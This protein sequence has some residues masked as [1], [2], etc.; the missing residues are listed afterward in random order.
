MLTV[1]HKCVLGFIVRNIEV[2][3]SLSTADIDTR[4]VHGRTPLSWACNRCDAH[5][6]WQLLQFGADPNIADN[7]GYS[8]LLNAAWRGC[9][10]LCILLIES[11]ADILHASKCGENALHYASKLSSSDTETF[12]QRIL[13]AGG[14]KL[15]NVQD[16][17]GRAPLSWAAEFGT[18]TL[19]R[20]LL[21]NDAD[22]E[23]KD[24]KVWTPLLRSLRY[25]HND[26]TSLLLGHGASHSVKDKDG[27][28]SLHFAVRYGN[29]ATL[30]ILAGF[31]LNGLDPEA[32]TI[33]GYTAAD[34]FKFREESTPDEF[35]GA[36]QRLLDRLRFGSDS[37]DRQSIED[38]CKTSSEDVESS[39]A[40]DEEDEEDEEKGEGEFKRSEISLIPSF[41][42]I[43]FAPII[44]YWFGGRLAKEPGS[45]FSH[46]LVCRAT[47]SLTQQL[48][49]R[50][51]H[52]LFCALWALLWLLRYHGLRLMHM[53][54]W[55]NAPDAESEH[56]TL[57]AQDRSSLDPVEHMEDGNQDQV[58]QSLQ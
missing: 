54:T 50:I 30:E 19:A 58:Y 22:V 7:E 32:T 35:M 26:I 49:R 2:E 4:D 47:Y 24:N 23:I 27:W 36:F 5:A 46:V 41:K 40:T 11:G 13:G 17:R 25:N 37:E 48:S 16:D 28:T 29:V 38:H 1:L 20:L 33:G 3:L 18:L 15:I 43:W 8:P 31:N 10:E 55:C 21:V 39:V 53:Q 51:K 6:A 57:E 34:L 45:S 42:L 9:L 12:M 56:G 52:S 14:Q 44:G